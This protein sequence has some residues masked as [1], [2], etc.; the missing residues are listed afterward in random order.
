MCWPRAIGCGCSV[1][2][3][4][5]DWVGWKAVKAGADTRTVLR[6]CEIVELRNGYV[7][8]KVVIVEERV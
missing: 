3:G 5:G 1:E 2:D 6:R 7:Q 8:P 4:C